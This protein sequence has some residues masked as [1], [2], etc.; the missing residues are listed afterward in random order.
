MSDICNYI[1]DQ[2]YTSSIEV[3]DWI[4][5]DRIVYDA[6]NVQ[7]LLI[8]LFRQLTYEAIAPIFSENTRLCIC[9]SMLDIK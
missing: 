8:S 6:L 1:S 5:E 4:T 7:L 9:L 2:D 3:N